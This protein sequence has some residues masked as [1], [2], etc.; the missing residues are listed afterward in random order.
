MDITINNSGKIILAVNGGM[1]DLNTRG[2][3]TSTTGALNSW[4]RIAGGSTLNVDSV[5]GWRG[6]L[7]GY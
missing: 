2:V 1:S 3:W 7:M 5:D 4:T 6:I